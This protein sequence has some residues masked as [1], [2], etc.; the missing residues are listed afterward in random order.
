MLLR[1]IEREDLNDHYLDLLDELSPSS[2]EVNF[3]EEWSAFSSNE[4]HH[5]LVVTHG[6]SVVGTASLLL[7]HKLDGRVAGHV[8]DVVVSRPHRGEGLGRVLING[9]VE[10]ANEEKCY[11][12]LLNCSDKN[13]SFYSKFGFI[14]IDNGMKL[15][16][17]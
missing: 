10:I 9:L 15:V 5:V 14:K 13:V 3:D 12:I 17:Q 2:H 4:D 1:K 8:E 16:M 11:K 7:E 6:N